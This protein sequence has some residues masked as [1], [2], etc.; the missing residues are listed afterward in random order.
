MLQI[1]LN[2]QQTKKK[3]CKQANKQW[4]K[5]RESEE[6][7]NTHKHT[8]CTTFKANKKTRVKSE[9]AKALK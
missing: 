8:S 3:Q 1:K 2:Y 7:K 4:I 9:E 5:K 6:H